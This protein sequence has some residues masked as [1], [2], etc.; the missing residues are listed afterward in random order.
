M[1]NGIAKQKNEPFIALPFWIITEFFI[2][3]TFQEGYAGNLV[4]LKVNK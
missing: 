4:G 3:R 2:T 1:R